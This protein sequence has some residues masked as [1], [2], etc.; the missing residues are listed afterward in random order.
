MPEERTLWLGPGHAL[1][2]ALPA[3]G[4]VGGDGFAEAFLNNDLAE[5][6]WPGQDVPMRVVGN[7]TLTFW[8]EGN[9][10][11]APIII[12]GGPGEGY[13]FFNQ[14]GTD[15]GFIES[16]AVEYASA[17]PSQDVVSYTEVF[18]M[19]D[20]GLMVEPG[21]R[22][23]LLLTNLVLD[24]AEGDGPSIL[25]GGDTPSRIE[26]TQ[27]CAQARTWSVLESA[28]TPLSIPFHHGLLTG[29]VQPTAGV[30]HQDVPFTLHAE[31]DRITITMVQGADRNPLKDDM[32]ITV[33]DGAGQQVWS[34]GSPYTDEIGTLWRE[35]LGSMPPGEYV[36]RVNSYSGHAYE[37]TITVV[38]EVAA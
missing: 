11:P 31:T 17:L 33:L 29:A 36:A 8:S 19:P 5:W 9:A 12:G 38:Q 30:N 27:T 34:I 28:S 22:L 21:D 16:Y 3:A 24:D 2:E 20:G 14:F 4:R 7:L 15:R 23:R 10:M 13:H 6:T 37:G 32:D 25:F 26:F 35:N 18:A 1:V